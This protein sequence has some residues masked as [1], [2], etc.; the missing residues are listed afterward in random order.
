[1]SDDRAF[2]VAMQ[3]WLDAGS[4][5][6]PTPAIDAVL[7]A[8]RTTPQDRDLRISRR[9]TLMT[10][11][12][13]LAAGIALVAIVGLGAFAFLGG[14]SGP[15]SPPTPPPTVEPTDSPLPAATGAS[16]DTSDW[17]AYTSERYGFNLSRPRDWVE[18]HAIRD[19]ALPADA[20][21][22]SPASERFIGADLSVTAWSVPVAAG[23]SAQEWIDAYCPGSTAPCTGT[24]GRAVSTSLD[25]NPGVLIPFTSDSQAFFLIGDR[26]YVVA[27]WRPGFQAQLEAFLSTMEL[28]S[29]PAPAVTAPELTQEF[30]S[31]VHGY[32]LRF[33]GPWAP[34]PA[35]VPWDPTDQAGT[36]ESLDFFRASL[37]TGALRVA[38]TVVPV[39]MDPDA[40]I[41]RN[42]TP[43]GGDC[44]P[45][46]STLGV[47]DI[48]GHAARVRTSCGEVEA[49]VSVDGRAYLFTMFIHDSEPFTVAGARALFAAIVGSV[50][51]I[52]DVAAQTQ[53]PEGS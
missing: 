3:R 40:W 10:F 7:L 11:P 34:I 24:Q 17:V 27:A 15:G 29:G 45:D 48:D 21:W 9:F 41:S 20:D 53:G 2:D 31:A 18:T 1:M 43:P 51:F 52:P 13:R 36:D 33:P 46:R 47:I 35:T 39:G 42:I 44:G 12:M 23:T 38:S 28:L 6:T 49:T 50:V 26:M 8:I 5:R 14:N 22:Q 37:G 30:T 25:G 19:W 32:S 16:I 4:D